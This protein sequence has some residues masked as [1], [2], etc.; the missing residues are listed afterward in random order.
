MR[1]DLQMRMLA[2]FL[3][4]SGL[5]H[6]EDELSVIFAKG[7]QFSD[8]GGVFLNY[9]PDRIE[10]HLALWDGDNENT[11]IGVAYPLQTK[12]KVRV[13]WTPGFGIVENETD[14]LGTHWQFYNRFELSYDASERLNAGLTWIHYSNGSRVFNHNQTPNLGENFINLSL[15][16]AWKRKYLTASAL[17][18]RYPS[19][20]SQ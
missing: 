7:V 6:A 16:Y 5:A 19:G 3:A 18:P 2:C 14:I 13:G 9:Q 20:Y 10:S 8:K 4:F 11:A 1:N 17:P 15:R 12:G